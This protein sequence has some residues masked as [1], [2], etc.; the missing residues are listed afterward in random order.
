MGCHHPAVSNP[1]RERTPYSGNAWPIYR[2]PGIGARASRGPPRSE[3]QPEGLRRQQPHRHF[4]REYESDGRSGPL[5][6]AP[7]RREVR[8]HSFDHGLRPSRMG[9]VDAEGARD[10]QD[11]QAGILDRAHGT[12][13]R[14]LRGRASRPTARLQS[15][16]SS[17]SSAMRQPRPPNFFPHAVRVGALMDVAC[18]TRPRGATIGVNAM[19]P[20]AEVTA[21]VPLAL[22]R[23]R[24]QKS[25]ARALPGQL[26]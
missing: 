24:I 14:R 16:Q 2:L 11:E 21:A 20:P 9:E 17:S 10:D 25:E 26:T 3:V 4:D 6:H 15:W 19:K 8:S 18:T 12:F 1:L 5:D 23:V 13:R 22:L 7:T